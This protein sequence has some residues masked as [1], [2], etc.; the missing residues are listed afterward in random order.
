[1]SRDLNKNILDLT[2]KLISI[3]ST[4]ENPESLKGVLK[5]AKNELA[6]FEYKEFESNSIPSLLFYNTPELPEKFK[7]PNRIN[8]KVHQRLWRSFWLRI[9]HP[10]LPFIRVT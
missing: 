1:M 9:N 3:P 2:K 6:G 10:L 7:I 4:K 8:L 5:V